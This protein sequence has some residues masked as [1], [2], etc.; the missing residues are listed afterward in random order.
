[1]ALLRRRA[2]LESWLAQVDELLAAR[3]SNADDRE[4]REDDDER[5]AS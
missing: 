2:A 1:V 5:K 3:R 4:G